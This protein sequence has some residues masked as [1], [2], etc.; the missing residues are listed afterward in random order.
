MNDASFVIAAFLVFYTY[1]GYPLILVLLPKHLANLSSYEGALPAVT[2][3]IPA[4]N[5]AD[6]IGATIQSLLEVDYPLESLRAIVVSDAS[7]DDTDK[8]VQ[9]INDSR[10]ELL[11]LDVRAGKYGALQAILPQCSSDILVLADSSSIFEKGSLRILVNHFYNPEI[12]AVTGRKS[13]MPADNA[14]AEGEGLYWRYDAWLRENETRA[15][16][17]WVGVEGGFFAIRR[18]LFKLDFPR[19]IAADYAIGCRVYEQGYLHVYDPGARIFEPPSSGMQQE[20]L[21]KIRVIVRGINALFFFKHLL[22]PLKHPFFSFQNISHRLM[23]WLVPFFL[24]VLLVT[25]GLSQTGWIHATFYAQLAFYLLSMSGGIINL[26][27][28]WGRIINVPWYFTV[29]NVSA[30]FSWFLLCRKYDI[31]SPP[32][33][34]AVRNLVDDKEG[35]DIGR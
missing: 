22:N 35:G 29:V 2:V 5:E 8:I 24:I 21:R 28:V 17:S 30:L 6:F 26:P 33:R 27:G 15:R 31:W 11:R 4:R 34:R 19:H 10:V 16:A 32:Q 14:V 12:G 1:A 7:T 23:R 13:I 3:L 18:K 25:S 9:T 20:F